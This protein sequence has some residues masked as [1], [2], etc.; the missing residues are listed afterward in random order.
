MRLLLVEDE[1][2]LAHALRRGL[3]ADGFQVDVAGDGASGLEAARTGNYAAILL[4]VM[5]PRLSGY[6]VVRRMR[7]EQNWVPVMMLSAK[8]GPHD[9]A[10]GLDYGADDYLTKPFSYVVLLARLRALLRRG[11]EARPTVLEAADLRLDPATR[12]VTSAG[13][14][15]TLTPREYAVLEHLLRHPDRVVTKIELL[16]QVW[17]AN[18]ELDPNVVEVYVGY[19]R[20]KLGRDAIRTVRGVG[21]RIGG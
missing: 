2:R 1:A 20:R 18:A 13:E 15:V 9:Q 19:L 17:D 8:D 6:E 12:E 21:Y 14:P 10:D 16:D 7:A 11:H 3:A 4:D 5:L